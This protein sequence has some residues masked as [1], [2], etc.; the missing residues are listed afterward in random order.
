[1]A[2]DKLY[3]VPRPLVT[4]FTFSADT[5]AVFDEMLIRSVPFYTEVQRM[6]SE[7]V[8]D[9]AVSGSNIYDLGCSTGATFR[10]LQ[11]IE[12][13]VNFIGIDSSADMLERAAEELR[14]ANF[15][16]RHELRRQDMHEGLHLENAS[17]VIMNLTLQF[18]RPL[19]RERVMQAIFD[20]MNHQGC[21]ILVEKVLAEESLMN[22]LF[23]KYYYDLK[24]RNGYSDIEISQKREALENVLIPYHLRENEL[25]LRNA[26]FR[27]TEVFFKWYNFC[28]LLA[29]K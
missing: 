2:K 10:M 3:A 8:G 23:I 29:L 7:I 22:R 12:Q 11:S 26:G 14:Q 18:V 21:L 20:G 4:D 19:F 1:M 28:G 6:I 5:A 17:V 13:D 25:L 24:R 16:R 27:C 9:F 15:T